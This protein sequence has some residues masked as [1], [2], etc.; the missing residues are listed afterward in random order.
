MIANGV[1]LASFSY[2]IERRGV[3]ISL[4]GSFSPSLSFSPFYPST[5]LYAALIHLILCSFFSLTRDPAMSSHL[6]VETNFFF[7]P[8]LNPS[9]SFSLLTSEDKGGGR[10]SLIL[11]PLEPM[12]KVRKREWKRHKRRESLID[13]L[14][15]ELQVNLVVVSL[16]KKFVKFDGLSLMVRI[17]WWLIV[18]CYLFR[19]WVIVAVVCLTSIY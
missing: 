13:A 10:Y 3:Q 16:W 8:S 15:A 17:S 4:A 1:G 11:R 7:P 9:D 2:S 18:E 14:L 19:N 12:K 5:S 6:R